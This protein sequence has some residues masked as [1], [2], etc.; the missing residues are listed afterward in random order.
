MRARDLSRTAAAFPLGIFCK[1]IFKLVSQT[2]IDEILKV[3]SEYWLAS[4]EREIC[5]QK[6]FVCINFRNDFAYFILRMIYS[7]SDRSQ[8]GHKLNKTNWTWFKI[9]RN[10]LLGF[11]RLLVD[12]KYLFCSNRNYFN[13]LA[14]IDLNWNE[15]WKTF[16][17]AKSNM[18]IRS[19]SVE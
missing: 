2:N 8:C 1:N 18:S 14:F 4:W 16:S 17:Q 7:Q 19:Q 9:V 6:S 5:L 10:I 15:W 11:P 3:L 13:C 12:R